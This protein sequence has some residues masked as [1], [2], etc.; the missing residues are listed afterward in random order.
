VPLSTI[1]RGLERLNRWQSEPHLIATDCYRLLLIAT[2][3]QSE[4]HQFTNVLKNKLMY[5][6][7]GARQLLHGRDFKHVCKKLTV[8]ADGK[9]YEHWIAL[10][11]MA[12]VG[13]NGN[14]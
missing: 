2:D 13:L 4:P 3:W 14:T 10:D 1:D 9:R 5:L 7:Y 12:L 8:I 11:C 6:R